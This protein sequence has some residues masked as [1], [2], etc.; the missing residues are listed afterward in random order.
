M[1]LVAT[2]NLSRFM[3]QSGMTSDVTVPPDNHTNMGPEGPLPT[4]SP[5]IMKAFIVAMNSVFLPIVVTIGL[6]GNSITIYVFSQEKPKSSTTY[7]VISLAI[8]DLLCGILHVFYLLLQFR[9][10]DFKHFMTNNL[11]NGFFMTR[12]IFYVD[13]MSRLIKVILVIERCFAVYIPLR[14][15]IILTPRRTMAA[16]TSVFCLVLLSSIPELLHIGTKEDNSSSSTYQMALNAIKEHRPVFEWYGNLFQ[17]LYGVVTLVF[18]SCCNIAIIIGV[19][20]SI[21]IT[22]N[23][24]NETVL[25]RISRQRKMTRMLLKMSTFYVFTCLPKDIG[26]AILLGDTHGKIVYDG[27]YYF[28]SVLLFGLSLS[29]LN[30]S[31]NFIIYGASTASFRQK[32]LEACYCCRKNA[33]SDSPP[34]SV[35]DTTLR[36]RAFGTS[37]VYTMDTPEDGSD[38]QTNTSEILPDTSNSVQCLNITHI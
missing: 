7:L 37:R 25:R 3:N 21:Y 23:I 9:N 30:N 28:Q 14:V 27:N 29:F 8:A 34:D 35:S 16:V 31:V 1:D 20:N 17:I 32:Y 18:T 6:I 38:G 22:K 19:R 24:T 36:S 12:L 33:N 4:F 5:D 10:Y 26:A 11:I 2:G 15:H 13:G